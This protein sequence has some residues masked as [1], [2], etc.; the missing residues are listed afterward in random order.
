MNRPRSPSRRCR[1]QPSGP[2]GPRGR[3]GGLVRA[4]PPAPGQRGAGGGLTGWPPQSPVRG[5]RYAQSIGRPFPARKKSARVAKKALFALHVHVHVTAVVYP[6][7]RGQ[8]H[9][10]PRTATTS[11]G[12]ACAAPRGHAAGAHPAGFC[13]GSPGG[14]P[15]GI[16][17]NSGEPRGRHGGRV[18]YSGPGDRFRRNAHSAPRRYREMTMRYDRLTV[19]LLLAFVVSQGT[20]AATSRVTAAP[21]APAVGGN[22]KFPIRGNRKPHTLLVGGGRPAFH[23]VVETNSEEAGRRCTD[24]RRGCC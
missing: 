18:V 16:V 20:L 7:P 22:C 2:D 5:P 9:L 15:R 19:V 3:E 4:G 6:Q 21:A 11:L 24:G 10:R 14:W 23:A 13:V 1:H 17:G 8:Q 12:L